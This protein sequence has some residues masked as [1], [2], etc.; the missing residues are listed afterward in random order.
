MSHPWKYFLKCLGSVL[1]ILFG[2]S[3]AAHSET[4]ELK[5]LPGEQVSSDRFASYSQPV[6]A[7]AQ[8]KIPSLVF[9]LAPARVKNY[10]DISAKFT[11]KGPRE[12]LLL[13]NGFV[14]IDY[15][16]TDDIVKPYKDIKEAGV[17]VFVT[18]DTLLHLYHIQF[19]ET[20]KNIEEKEFYPDLI[21]LSQFLMDK[22]LALSSSLKKD[23]KDA[24]RRNA[25]F[26]AVAL[27][28][29]KPDASIPKSVSKEVEWE[30]DHIDKHAGFPGSPFDPSDLQKVEENSIFRYMEDYS[31]YVPRGHY[32]RSEELKRYFKAMMW[33]GRMTFL[34][35]GLE[36]HGPIAPPAQALISPESAKVQTLQAALIASAAGEILPDQRS[37]AQVWDRIYLVT[38]FYVG[39]SDD[40]S[41]YDYRDVLKKVWGTK[42][43]RKDLDND[44]K[45][46]EF[47]AEFARKPSPQ[48]Y[49]GTGQSGLKVGPGEPFTPEQLDKIL[50]QTK[51]MRF[52]G[53]R[54]VPD[55]YLMSQLVSPAAGDYLGKRNPRPFT[56]IPIP[57]GEVR[58]F[59]RGLDVMRL[60]GSRRAGEILQ[61]EGD[62]EYS[63][64]Q[65]QFDKLQKEFAALNEK[66]WNKN[67]YWSWLNAL[68]AL[69]QEFPAGYQ[70]FMQNPA[71][72]DKELNAALGSWSS[73]RHD[74]ILYVKQ[75]YTPTMARECA[76]R[77]GPVEKPVVGY[78]EPVAEFYAR[79]VAMTRMT[80]QGLKDLQVLDPASEARLASLE[81]ILSRL[82]EITRK[83]LRNE[84]LQ[85]DDYAFIRNFGESLQ[86]AI[87]GVDAKGMKTTII[88]DVHT[89]QNTK[90]CLEEGTGYVDLIL[91]AYQVPDG[92]IIIGAGPVLSY[93]EFKHPMG[94]RLTDE[95]WQGML[96]G[97]QAPEKPGWAKSYTAE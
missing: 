87:A 2:T 97:G 43:S 69:L 42:F 56:W 54:F 24:A 66:D 95:K 86:S 12:K 20:L 17:P 8:P 31:Q 35:K 11:L 93:Y 48:I 14:V 28:L 23:L 75:S 65:S 59:P 88:A 53:Q 96:A 73:L 51:G 79:L 89:D 92:R 3:C 26:F 67:L 16:R 71:W 40:L 34:L 74:T 13:K 85:E 78:V 15:G 32:T 72:L 38:A 10:Q 57:E 7:E 6:K 60:L 29:L 37:V 27:K 9:P 63:F 4:I 80:N 58:G 84:E 55:S 18:S 46:F 1:L 76:E 44:R 91:A 41:I 94:D 45:L 22:S 90:N 21:K 36:P 52:M 19:D 62:T 83:E 82:L 77:P 30:L 50:D 68:R 5:P 81:E 39:F 33:Y 64:Y 47:K 25:A 61:S 49:G 70:S